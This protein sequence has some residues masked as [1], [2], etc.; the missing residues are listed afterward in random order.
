MGLLAFR[1]NYLAA[2]GGYGTLNSREGHGRGLVHAN[3]EQQV[4]QHRE[5]G[6]GRVPIYILLNPPSPKRKNFLGFVQ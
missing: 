6:E 5:F 4:Q 3:K 1:Y 2:V